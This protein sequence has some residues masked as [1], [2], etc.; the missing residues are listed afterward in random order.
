M[1]W[2][3]N[4]FSSKWIGWAQ[5]YFLSHNVCAY[6]VT[7]FDLHAALCKCDRQFFEPSIRVS[8]HTYVTDVCCSKYGWC[9]ETMADYRRQHCTN[10]SGNCSTVEMQTNHE[11]QRK[12]I[13]K[14]KQIKWWHCCR[15]SGFYRRTCFQ[16]TATTRAAISLQLS[17]YSSIRFLSTHYV[18]YHAEGV[19][20]LFKLPSAQI[21]SVNKKET[22][23]NK[24]TYV[25]RKQKS[26]IKNESKVLILPSDYSGRSLFPSVSLRQM[27]VLT[28]LM[29]VFVSYLWNSVNF[30]AIY[31]VVI[32]LYVLDSI[33]WNKNY[34]KCAA[35]R[36]WICSTLFSI[37]F[38]K[39]KK[40]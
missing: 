27:F 35:I 11:R 26:K 32:A 1:K 24:E 23:N 22:D 12:L 38:K 36:T 8:T 14:I 37:E 30:A 17:K 9:F 3:W 18:K 13:K 5:Y 33:R 15:V 19:A 21:K 29:L 16:C 4:A 2:Q 39:K 31:A 34:F 20:M 28:I 7:F 25:H 6:S 40:T 10:H